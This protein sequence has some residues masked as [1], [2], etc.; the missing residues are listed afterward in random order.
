MKQ[1]NCNVKKS[2]HKFPENNNSLWKLIL[3]SIVLI[4]G[5]NACNNL[6]GNKNLSNNDDDIII[7]I[8]HNSTIEIDSIKKEIDL[9]KDLYATYVFGKENF[10]TIAEN[11]CTPKILQKLKDDYYYD[12]EDGNCYAVWDFRTSYQDGPYDV[13]KVISIEVKDDGW[14]DVFYF[15]MG[16]KGTTSLKLIERDNKVLIDGIKECTLF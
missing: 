3:I 5:S 1:C 8:P 2:S 13:S 12:C 15:D 6:S 16:F 10:S 7:L 14:F 9:I 11:I 4:L